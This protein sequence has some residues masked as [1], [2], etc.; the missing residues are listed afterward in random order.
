MRFST[1]GGQGLCSVVLFQQIAVVI[2]VYLCRE[3]MFF[4]YTSSLQEFDI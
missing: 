2:C 1:E 3:F 4:S